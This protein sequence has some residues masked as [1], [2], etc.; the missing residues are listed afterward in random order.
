V[1]IKIIKRKGDPIITAPDVGNS[2][3]EIK[4]DGKTRC[5]ANKHE[6]RIIS[7]KNDTKVPHSDKHCE[8]SECD[9]KI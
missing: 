8:K 9:A 6:K 7:N 2:F 1:D 3:G 5:S 4:C